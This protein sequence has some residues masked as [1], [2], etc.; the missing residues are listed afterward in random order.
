MSIIAA[1]KG[2]DLTRFVSKEWVVSKMAREGLRAVEGPE[3]K[4]QLTL[5]VSTVYLWKCTHLAVCPLDLKVL[6]RV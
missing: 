4:A 1:V 5:Y 3:S 6:Y 2:H